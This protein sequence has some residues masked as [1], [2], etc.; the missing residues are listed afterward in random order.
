VTKAKEPLDALDVHLRAGRPDDATRLA[1]VF[2]SAW[3]SAY[4]GVVSEESL[5][6]LDE[7]QIATWLRSLL[8]S[9]GSSTIVA[10]A[11]DGELLGFCRLGEDPDITGCGHIFSVYVAPS[12]S[13]RGLG[14]RLLARA[15]EDRERRLPGDVTLWV[16]EENAPARRLYSGF[17][18]SPDGARRVEPEYGAEELR[19]RRVSV[20]GS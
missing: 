3:L 14:H 9:A 2:V 13:R 15:L 19:L 12:A 1:T 6:R 7:K 20:S 5:S 4:Q 11:N 8:S 16:F 10:E 18:F 17:G